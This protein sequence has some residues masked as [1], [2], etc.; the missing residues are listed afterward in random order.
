M[1]QHL[2]RPSPLPEAC[3]TDPEPPS[4]THQPLCIE[5]GWVHF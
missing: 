1:V 2:F 3:L 4:P 5:E